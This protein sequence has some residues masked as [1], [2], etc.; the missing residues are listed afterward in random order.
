MFDWDAVIIGGGPAGLSAGLYLARARRRV[1]LLEKETFGGTI[2]NVELIENYPGFSEGIAGSRLASEMLA[3]ATRFG[4][5][6]KLAEVTGIEPFSSC[7]WVK[8]ADGDYTT[9]VVIIAGGA[10]S[11][12]LNVPGEEELKDKGVIECALCD[13]GQFAGRSVV[14]CGGGDAG[15]TQALYLTRIAS[16]VIILEAKPV[17]TASPVLQ[18]KVAANPKLEV[19]TGVLVAAISGRDRVESVDVV[20]TDD[21]SQKIETDGVL[22]HIGLDAN[23]D[24]LDG[25]VP[26]D[27]QGQIIVNDRMESEVPY[28]LAAGDIRSGSPRQAISAA[29]DGVQAAITAQRLLQQLG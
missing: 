7:Q 13:G 17:L 28:I 9:A 15:V 27:G 4:L 20:G 5:E 22:V 25:V 14:V 11:R 10:R 6:T 23:T 1:L 3:Q 18:E 19:H 12:R 24:Y 16:K 21:K 2:K 29:G 8:T 26:L